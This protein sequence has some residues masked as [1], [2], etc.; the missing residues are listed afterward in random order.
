MSHHR[1]EGLHL[2]MELDQCVLTLKFSYGLLAERQLKWTGHVIRIPENRLT[3]RVLCGKLKEGRRF[4]GGQYQ[5]FSGI[6]K[7][8]TQEECYSP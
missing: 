2:K 5:R 1:K 7:G 8:N 4:V 6:S 3:R